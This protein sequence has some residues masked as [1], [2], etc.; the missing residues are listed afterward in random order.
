MGPTETT[1]E[2]ER[3]KK[4]DQAVSKMRK[5]ERESLTINIDEAW[6]EHKK[7]IDPFRFKFQGRTYDVAS[8]MPA[9]FGTF[10]TE[11]CLTEI[12][13]GGKKLLQ[14]EIPE[15]RYFEFLELMFGVE[16]KLAICHSKVSFAFVND[17]L[18]PP[19]MRAWGLMRKDGELETS[20]D[21][22]DPEKKSSISES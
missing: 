21:V 1:S 19:V 10:Y 16:L 20:T 4:L 11:H 3:V 6:T 5:H 17:K 13:L 8:A 14:F 7:L 12:T 9:D 15:S 18:L 22:G 2:A